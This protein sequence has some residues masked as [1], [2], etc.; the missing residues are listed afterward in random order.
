[1]H[2]FRDAPAPG[3]HPTELP[4]G[5][6][7]PVRF[8][9][10]CISGAARIQPPAGGGWIASSYIRR[11]HSLRSRLCWRPWDPFTPVQLTNRARATLARS[12]PSLQAWIT[13]DSPQTLSPTIVVDSRAAGGRRTGRARADDPIVNDRRTRCSRQ[14]PAWNLRT[15]PTVRG[16]GASPTVTWPD[17]DGAPERI[18]AVD[19]DGAHTL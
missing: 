2:L 14:P 19:R 15:E 16:A 9:P 8:W 12:Y 17:S 6:S 10:G 7:P 1:V 18:C 4:G 11:C 13:D 3:P 5:E